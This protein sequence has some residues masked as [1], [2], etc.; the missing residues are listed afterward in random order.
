MLISEGY[1]SSCILSTSESSFIIVSVSGTGTGTCAAFI[2]SASSE[3]I[4]IS[5][6]FSVTGEIGACDS[7]LMGR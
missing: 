6:M 2:A 5:G 7:T 3:V 4:V 1:N